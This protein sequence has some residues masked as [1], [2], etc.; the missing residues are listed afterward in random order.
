MCGCICT[1]CITRARECMRT[2]VDGT[3]MRGDIL[4]PVALS[5]GA[6]GTGDLSI[7][8]GN[9][10]REQIIKQHSAHGPFSVK[11]GGKVDTRRLTHPAAAQAAPLSASRTC[12]TKALSLQNLQKSCQRGVHGSY[13]GSMCVRN[14]SAV[15]FEQRE[16]AV[17]QPDLETRGDQAREVQ[18]LLDARLGQA[19]QQEVFRAA[20]TSK[21]HT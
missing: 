3:Y 16:H 1:Y 8:W 6:P 5:S 9:L 18:H 21:H 11:H 19:H 12:K 17:Q 13:G 20:C 4:R 10:Q 15:T 14:A 7:S 2:H